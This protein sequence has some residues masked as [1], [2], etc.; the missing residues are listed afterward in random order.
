MR[1]FFC[2]FINFLSMLRPWNTLLTW[3]VYVYTLVYYSFK[4]NTRLQKCSKGSSLG[5]KKVN[6]FVIYDFFNLIL[7]L[8]VDFRK[9]E[10]ILNFQVVV[11]TLFIAPYFTLKF[12]L[13]WFLCNTHFLKTFFFWI[14]AFTLKMSDAVKKSLYK[15]CETAYNI[16]NR[17][18]V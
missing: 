17:N 13:M 12:G 2:S 8:S 1:V 14:M 4:N 10:I 15:V 5:G 11:G 9:T 6:L 16:S 7:C 3:Y 18:L